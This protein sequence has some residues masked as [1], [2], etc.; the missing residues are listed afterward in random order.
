LLG[1]AGVSGARF[2]QA[3]GSSIR[4]D[5]DYLGRSRNEQNPAVGPFE[6]P[7]GKVQLKIWP[8]K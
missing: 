1:Y 3:D 7:A 8:K 2:E 5:R 4:V 6:L